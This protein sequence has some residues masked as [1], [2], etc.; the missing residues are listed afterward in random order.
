MKNIKHAYI[1]AYNPNCMYQ[2]YNAKADV[3]AN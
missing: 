3:G 1:L 2:Q